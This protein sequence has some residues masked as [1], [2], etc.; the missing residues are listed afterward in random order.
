[1]LLHSISARDET[2]QFPAP[3]RDHTYSSTSITSTH[4]AEPL[5]A[6]V[7]VDLVSII[8]VLLLLY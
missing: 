3:S 4:V 5:D 6:A 1:M 8:L 7:Q 2:P